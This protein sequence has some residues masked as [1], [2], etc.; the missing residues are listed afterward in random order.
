VNSPIS[1]EKGQQILLGKP[2]N[3]LSEERVERLRELV[4]NTPGIVE[5]HL[6][7]CFIPETM[8][9]AAQILFVVL[10][11]GTVEEVLVEQ[12]GRGIYEI[13]PSGEYLEIIPLEPDNAMLPAIRS[14]ECSLGA[15]AVNAKSRPWWKIW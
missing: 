11:A 4:A 5:A 14:T 6:P 12:L 7:Q 2:A 15:S 13:F 1:L 9:K 3:P 8:E 10:A